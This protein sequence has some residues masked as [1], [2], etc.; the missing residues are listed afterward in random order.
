MGP[1]CQEGLG[2]CLHCLAQ[3]STNRTNFDDNSG[4]AGDLGESG[5]VG[6]DGYRCPG[7][8]WH[9]FCCVGRLEGLVVSSVVSSL[10]SV[11]AIAANTETAAAT[12]DLKIRGPVPTAVLGE[13]VL[14]KRVT[15]IEDGVSCD[16]SVI[17]LGVSD[18]SVLVSNA[19]DARFSSRFSAES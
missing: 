8:I 15:R 6:F 4:W 3:E 10:S 2:Y 18:Y 16:G 14:E 9:G 11:A 12:A 1:G 19:V 5:I 17:S 7:A 13:T